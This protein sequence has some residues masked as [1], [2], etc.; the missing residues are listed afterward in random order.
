MPIQAAIGQKIVARTDIKALRKTSWQNVTVVTFH[1]NVTRKNKAGKKRMK[2]IG[3]LK[4][5]K[6]PSC[7]YFQWTKMK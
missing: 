3:W 1:V 5:H 6:K 2:A 7:Q 4:Y